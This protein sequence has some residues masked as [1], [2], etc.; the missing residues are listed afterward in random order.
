MRPTRLRIRW[1]S[2]LAVFVGGL[3]SG[4]VLTRDASAQTANTPP[5]IIEVPASGLM[6]RASD[7]TPIA[8]LA[9]DDRGG[10]LE[11][12]SADGTSTTRIPEDYRPGPG[13]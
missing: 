7:G 2:L 1:A 4:R 9:R 13:F 12:V 3:L 10:F 5:S 8:V 6:F 11:F